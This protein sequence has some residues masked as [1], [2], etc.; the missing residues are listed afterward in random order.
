MGGLALGAPT[1][2]AA[3]CRGRCWCWLLVCALLLLLRRAACGVLR[4][5]GRRLLAACRCCHPRAWPP[6]HA[7]KQ[8]PTC[9]PARW[10][11]SPSAPPGLPGMGAARG[12]ANC[13]C[14]LLLP[15]FRN[16]SPERASAKSSPILMHAG[17]A[18]RPG[19]RPVCSRQPLLCARPAVPLRM[20]SS[21]QACG[22]RGGLVLLRAAACL[23]R[24]QGLFLAH[25]S[26]PTRPGPHTSW[27]G[28]R[29]PSPQCSAV[30]S[31]SNLGRR[32]STFAGYLASQEASMAALISSC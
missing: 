6:Q 30:P 22:D 11:K 12:C 17:P 29:R 16:L 31:R 4:A 28:L 19:A 7:R 20:P 5:A 9:A 14:F 27:S 8:A 21:R 1:W 15:C 3:P 2:I 32:C 24:P 23:A 13:C 10:L 18:H 26:W 25:T